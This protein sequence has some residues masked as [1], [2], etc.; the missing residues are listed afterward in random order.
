MAKLIQRK[1]KAWKRLPLKVRQEI[2][3]HHEMVRQ[4]PCVITG[5]SDVTL[6]HC[7]GGS[8][9]A[10]GFHRGGSQRPNDWLVIP[11]VLDLHVGHKGIDG[12][13]GLETWEKINGTQLSHLQTVSRVLG[14]DVIYKA[15]LLEEL[16]K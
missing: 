13:E 1:T 3:D 6:H 11:I 10:A 5:R 12:S 15:K 4:L 2:S 16:K 7:H 9:K 8:I 14:V